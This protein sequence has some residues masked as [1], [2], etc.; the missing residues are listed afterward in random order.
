MIPDM[1]DNLNMMVR[2]SFL[3]AIAITFLASC[4]IAQ[5]SGGI[6][7]T[8]GAETELEVSTGN[9]NKILSFSPGDCNVQL[10]VDISSE[11]LSEG[12]G[13][14]LDGLLYELGSIQYAKGTAK[15]SFLLMSND[16]EDGELVDLASQLTSGDLEASKAVENSVLVDLMDEESSTYTRWVFSKRGAATLILIGATDGAFESARQLVNSDL[17]RM[18]E[19]AE[20]ENCG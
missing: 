16:Y 7:E 4:A 12:N 6:N 19:L 9:F 1:L 2:K 18:D 3:G 11:I 10:N 17:Q 14:I 20:L 5:D 13:S 8:T 15:F